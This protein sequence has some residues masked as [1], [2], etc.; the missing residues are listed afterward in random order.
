MKCSMIDT[1]NSHMTSLESSARSARSSD[2]GDP[3]DGRSGLA[4]ARFRVEGA[5]GFCP[6]SVRM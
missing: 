5:W 2:D 6:L 4:I 3:D 1:K